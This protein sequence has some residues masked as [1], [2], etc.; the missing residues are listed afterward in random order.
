MTGLWVAAPQPDIEPWCKAMNIES[1]PFWSW[2]R[3]L[4]ENYWIAIELSKLRRAHADRLAAFRTQL[5]STTTI[6]E[7]LQAQ[8]QDPGDRE[9][10]IQQDLLGRTGRWTDER[11]PLQTAVAQ[12]SARLRGAIH[13]LEETPPRRGKPPFSARKKLLA[14]V[15]AHLRERGACNTE[16]DARAAAAELLVYC[17]IEMPEHRR[18]IERAATERHGNKD[19]PGPKSPP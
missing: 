10:L 14:S 1:G 7:A 15:A 9:V 17:R 19:Q 6:L 4:F 11:G 3:P 2:Y 16:E 5:L 8:D 13:L 12:Y 18:S